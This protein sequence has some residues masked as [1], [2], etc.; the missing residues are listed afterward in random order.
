MKQSVSNF[1]PDTNI[2]LPLVSLHVQTGPDVSSDTVTQ[3]RQSPII[4]WN[5]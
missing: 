2:T 1:T 4:A 3:P 5:G